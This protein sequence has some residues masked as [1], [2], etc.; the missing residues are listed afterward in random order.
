MHRRPTLVK[1]FKIVADLRLIF[2][3]VSSYESTSEVSGIDRS[4]APT[5]FPPFFSQRLNA[6]AAR[7]MILISTDDKLFHLENIMKDRG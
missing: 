2:R 6:F 3:L 5:F 4:R 7:S 1:Y